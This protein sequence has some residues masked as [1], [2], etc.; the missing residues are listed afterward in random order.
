MGRLSK[1]KVGS[2]RKRHPKYRSLEALSKEILA[3]GRID[4]DELRMIRSRIYADGVID[5]E[6]ADFL[7]E[8]NDATSGN[9][10]GWQ[11][12]FCGSYRDL[13]FARRCLSRCRRCR[14][15]QVAHRTHPRRWKN[16]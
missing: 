3:D 10:P 6:E 1:R 7:F 11:R 16:R 12:L 15:S 2:Q 4:K 9:H 8:L 14:R 5:E 13:C